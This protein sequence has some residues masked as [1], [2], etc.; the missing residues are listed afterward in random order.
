MIQRQNKETDYIEFILKYQK[1][2]KFHEWNDKIP[3]QPCRHDSCSECHGTGRKQNGAI[4]IHMISCP[5][6]KCTPTHL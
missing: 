3:T 4:C 5:C 6:P 2:I 1:E